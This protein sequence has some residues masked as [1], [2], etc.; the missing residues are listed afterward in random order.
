VPFSRDF[1]LGSSLQAPI[2]SSSHTRLYQSESIVLLQVSFRLSGRIIVMLS[3]ALLLILDSLLLLFVY[4]T[5]R[6]ELDLPFV[7]VALDLTGTG[8]ATDHDRIVS[9]PSK[10]SDW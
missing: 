6:G 2:V 1:F 9:S 10:P 8:S 4:P 3:S 7:T 5:K